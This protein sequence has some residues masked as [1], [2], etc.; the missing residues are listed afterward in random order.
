VSDGPVSNLGGSTQARNTLNIKQ[1]VQDFE[2]GAVTVTATQVELKAGATAMH[3]RWQLIVYPPT[4][5]TIYWGKSGVTSSTGA[6][7]SAGD[8]PVTFDMYPNTMVPIY[9]VSDG[10]NRDVRVVESK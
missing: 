6:P 3:Q 1:G 7:L 8:S 9:A 4:V 2:N 5:G 10:T